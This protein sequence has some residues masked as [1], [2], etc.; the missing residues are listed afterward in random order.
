MDR[1]RSVRRDDRSS[2]RRRPLPHDRQRDRS[3]GATDDV[4]YGGGVY[5]TPQSNSGS[6]WDLL[7]DAA[8]LVV[9]T[10]AASASGSVSIQGKITN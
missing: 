9:V 6:G 8:F 7:G 5:T 1:V 2:A 3:S 4:E 10:T